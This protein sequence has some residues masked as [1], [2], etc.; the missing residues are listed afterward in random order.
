MGVVAQVT[1]IPGHRLKE[2]AAD[3]AEL[4]W[5]IDGWTPRPARRP[6]LQRLFSRASGQPA[7]T[8]EWTAPARADTLYLDKAWHAIHFLLAHSADPSESSESFLLGGHEICIG[9]WTARIR[10]ADA[11]DEIAW[12]LSSFTREKLEASYDSTAWFESGVYLLKDFPEPDP[13]LRD[14]VVEYALALIE[15]LDETARRQHGV[16]VSIG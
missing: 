9:G 12:N 6:L 2:L 16:V 4:A 3:P 13:S 8:R 1:R 14:S 7:P 5:Y 15:F 10:F 11:V